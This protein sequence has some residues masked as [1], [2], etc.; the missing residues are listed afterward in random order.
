MCVNDDKHLL[1]GVSTDNE[2][3]SLVKI[4]NLFK[5]GVNY[6]ILFLNRFETCFNI[7]TEDEEGGYV[8]KLFKMYAIPC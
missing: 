3:A 5:I 7:V 6:V 2:F 8:E 4:D 1:H